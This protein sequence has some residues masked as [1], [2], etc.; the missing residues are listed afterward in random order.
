MMNGTTGDRLAK[1]RGYVRYGKS[2]GTGG[3]KLMRS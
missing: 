1:P 2:V 3:R